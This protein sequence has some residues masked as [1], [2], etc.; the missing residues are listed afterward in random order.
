VERE[1]ARIQSKA[2]K[3]HRLANHAKEPQMLIFLE[4]KY[5]FRR[6]PAQAPAHI[7]EAGLGL[8]VGTVVLPAS[9]P[10]E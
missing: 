3:A 1:S 6:C 7:L 10:R 9:E 5:G 8:R 2:Q 4:S